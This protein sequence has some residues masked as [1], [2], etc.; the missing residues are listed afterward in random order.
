MRRT[1]LLLLSIFILP[2]LSYGQGPP[3]PKPIIETEL[4]DNS[5]KIRGIELERLKREA[6]KPLPDEDAAA[7]ERRFRETKR[8]FED[9]QKLQ[10]RIVR[11]YRTGKTINYARI[12]ESAS[13][14]SASAAW[15]DVNVFGAERSEGESPRREKARREDVRDLIIELDGAIGKFVDSPV[16][17]PSSVLEKDDY[18]EAQK[19]LRG[20]MLISRRL[21]AASMA[22]DQ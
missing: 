5:T 2:V 20:I 22:K 6:H 15:L 4:R 8:R 21:A 18:Q 16:F 17:Q 14:M 7:R 10:N 3:P 19:R 9:I 11:T 12:G 1:V 13:E